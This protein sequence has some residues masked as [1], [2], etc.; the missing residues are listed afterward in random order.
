MT[1][2]Y[3]QYTCARFVD[4]LKA[5]K[6]LPGQKGGSVKAYRPLGEL[7]RTITALKQ[8]I[9]KLQAEN[10]R[11]KGSRSD[12]IVS[13]TVTSERLRVILNIGYEM[14]WIVKL[15]EIIVTV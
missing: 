8:V 11:L 9:E 2:I 6:A 3:V 14:H 13:R 12:S 4:A 5:E 7:E 10:Q 15:Y 1:D